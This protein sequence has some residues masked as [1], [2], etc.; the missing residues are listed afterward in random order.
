MSILDSILANEKWG[1]VR[2]VRFK[3]EIRSLTDYACSH[4]GL[5]IDCVE[6]KKGIEEDRAQRETIR[7]QITQS[8]P[9]RALQQLGNEYSKAYSPLMQD[10]IAFAKGVGIFSIKNKRIECSEKTRRVCDYMKKEPEKVE[11]AL[12]QLILDSKYKAYIYFLAN[13]SKL[14]GEMSIPFAFR[15]RTVSSGIK[16]FLYG[17][18]FATDIPSFF[19]IRD[20]FYD[21]G[22]VNWRISPEKSVE[23]IFMTSEIAGKEMNKSD[24]YLEEVR[25]QKCNLF[26]NKVPTDRTFINTLGEN[27][28]QLSRGNYASIVDLL[29]LRDMVCQV[30]KISDTQFNQKLLDMYHNQQTAFEI[31][32]S[33]GRIS[34]RR[35]SGLLIKAVNTIKIE[36]GVYATYIRLRR[37]Y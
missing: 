24:L 16:A 19:T 28:L 2:K 33:Q 32:L 14:G 31:E 5:N 34:P 18:G 15:N 23:E 26:I 7:M 25:L 29:E 1:S 27:Y 35:Y 6:I 8:G 20:L 36:E 3:S 9:R 17:K 22:L 37:R 12:L 11:K 10:R 4:D 21:F 30:L 13:L